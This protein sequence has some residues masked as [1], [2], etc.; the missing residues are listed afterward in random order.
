VGI[1]FEGYSLFVESRNLGIGIA[2]VNG[3]NLPKF[4]DISSLMDRKNP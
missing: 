4:F 1:N 3:S 2:I